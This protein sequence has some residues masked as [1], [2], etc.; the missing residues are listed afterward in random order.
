MILCPAS[1]I[2]EIRLVWHAQGMVC[3]RHS[4]LIPMAKKHGSLVRI[5]TESLRTGILYDIDWYCMM[6]WSCSGGADKVWHIDVSSST[7]ASCDLLCILV[8]D[9]L[10]CVEAC[11][12]RLAYS[13]NHLPNSAAYRQH[14]TGHII[15]LTLSYSYCMTSEFETN[16]CSWVGPRKLC[17]YKHVVFCYIYIQ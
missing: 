17:I 10:L 4:M 6:F 8:S 3:Q 1:R 11:L 15:L 16:F 13:L 12:I 5:Y 7:S 2:R 9:F 14:T